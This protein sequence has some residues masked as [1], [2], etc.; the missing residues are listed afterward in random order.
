M[1]ASK[2][3]SSSSSSSSSSDETRARY[4]GE[5]APLL[6]A[7]REIDCLSPTQKK[8][9]H[10]RILRTLFR[11]RFLSFRVRLVPALAALGML[12]IG[13]A[14]F[15]TAER[16]GLLAKFGAKAPTSA[17]A[18]PKQETRKRRGSGARPAARENAPGATEATLGE[19]AQVSSVTVVL[20]EI[21]DPLLFSVAEASS[22]DCNSC[23]TQS[24]ANSAPG[25]ITLP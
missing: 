23:H 25:R 21:P 24:G 7:A 16:L 20:P 1:R 8:H 2:N 5:I 10:R 11:S 15:A 22:G 4:L 17:A 12:V 9:V 3:S 19:G 13:G 18:Q 6:D 14:A